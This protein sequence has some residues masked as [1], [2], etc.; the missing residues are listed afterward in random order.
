MGLDFF[1]LWFINHN[2][3]SKIVSDFCGAPKV[4]HNSAN[5]EFRFARRSLRNK[6]KIRAYYHSCE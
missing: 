6:G 3:P 2:R 4:V 5:C 1:K